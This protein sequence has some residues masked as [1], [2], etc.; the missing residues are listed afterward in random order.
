[1]GLDVISTDEIGA[2]AFDSDD[3]MAIDSS[4]AVLKLVGG[5]VSESVIVADVPPM[6]SFGEMTAPEIWSGAGCA[7]TVKLPS[8]TLPPA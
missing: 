2:I 8:D 5:G 6:M 7:I 3:G 4:P 1:M